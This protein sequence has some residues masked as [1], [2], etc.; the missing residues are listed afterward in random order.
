MVDVLV[1]LDGATDP[2]AA[3]L[4]RANMPAYDRIAAAGTVEQVRW[5]PPG[6]EPGSESAIPVILG[7]TP[8]AP[9]DR[10]AL[11]A[12]ARGIPGDDWWRVDVFAEDGRRG[13]GADVECAIHRIASRQAP[14]GPR[15]TRR[16][17][18]HR[19]LVQGPLPL[20]PANVR[21]WPRGIIP[22]RVL[23]D[24]TCVVA[25][26]G[27]AA[28]LAQLLGARVVTPAGAT[29][30]SDTDLAAK[31]AAARAAD[32][33]RVVIHVGAPDEAAHD[34]DPDGKV[35]VLERIDRELLAPLAETADSLTITADHG[36]DPLTGEHDSDPVPLIR[37]QR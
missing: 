29:G 8:T 7:W 2:G 13:S 24:D 5:T 26:P 4:A 30:R 37:W 6:M 9:I 14:G 21:A 22:P 25:A 11:E 28:G 19:L 23:S 31:L 3:S 36:C 17:G 16:I 1:I 10:A 33:A 18:G 20:L 15:R 32:A 12:V 34:R 35:A 27:G